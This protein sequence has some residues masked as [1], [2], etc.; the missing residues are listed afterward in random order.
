VAR[1]MDIVH[2]GREDSLEDI[3]HADQDAR[4]EAEKIITR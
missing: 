3:L 1:T 2:T 4:R